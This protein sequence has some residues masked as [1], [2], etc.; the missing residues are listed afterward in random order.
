MGNFIW[1]ETKESINVEKHGID[2]IFAARVFSD[3]GRKIFIDSK[4][5]SKE[6]R[7]YCIGK[8]DN[9]VI[10]VRFTYRHDKV[11]IFGAGFWRKGKACYEKKNE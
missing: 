11:R 1:D 10:T 6:E 4:H 2:F 9:M 8:V 3:P 5:D 7:F